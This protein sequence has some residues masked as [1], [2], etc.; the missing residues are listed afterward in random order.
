MTATQK[1]I[2]YCAVAFAVFLIVSIIGGIFGAAASLPMFF[3][4]AAVGEMESYAVTE[5]VKRLEIDLGGARLAVQTG[6]C[7]AVESDHTCLKVESADDVLSIKEDHPVFRLATESAQVILTVPKDFVFECVT[8]STGAGTVKADALLAEELSL[9]LGAGEVD[10]GKLTATAKASIN[11]GAGELKIGGGE[12]ANLNLDIGVGEADLK[13]R[14]TGYCSI[15]YGVGEL[16]LT[17]LGTQE[18]Y[19]IILDKGVGKATLDGVKMTDDGAYGSGENTI[20]I[21]GGVGE[22]KIGF[23]PVLWSLEENLAA[24]R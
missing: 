4:D 22:V 24:R 10:I 12:L 9:D 7:F 5:P 3:D 20:E 8:I 18:D 13:S 6:D 11:S 2:K 23:A 17:L 16:E 1:V 15:D 19:E 21:D 14:L